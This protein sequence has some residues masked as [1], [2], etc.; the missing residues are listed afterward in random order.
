MSLIT[1]VC[2][3]CLIYGLALTF[4]ALPAVW[5]AEQPQASRATALLDAVTKAQW[6]ELQ[7]WT[8]EFIL[9]EAKTIL[10][11]IRKQPG[12]LGSWEPWVMTVPVDSKVQAELQEL[13]TQAGA[14]LNEMQH[15]DWE[16]LRWYL[17]EYILWQSR[18]YEGDTGSYIDDSYYDFWLRRCKSQSADIKMRVYRAKLQNSIQAHGAAVAFAATLT[19]EDLATLRIWAIGQGQEVASA[20]EKC[21]QKPELTEHWEPWLLTVPGNPEVRARLQEFGELKKS[22]LKEAADDSYYQDGASSTFKWYL[23]EYLRWQFGLAGDLEALQ[24]LGRGPENAWLEILKLKILNSD[25]TA[26]QKASAYGRQENQLPSA[27]LVIQGNSHS[28]EARH[29][30]L[31]QASYDPLYL[32]P[33]RGIII[34]SRP[35]GLVAYEMSTGKELWRNRV[36]QTDTI[37]EYFVFN[38]YIFVYQC[39]GYMSGQIVI[40]DT[41]NGRTIWEKDVIGEGYEG[42]IDLEEHFM[43]LIT[44]SLAIVPLN[45]DLSEEGAIKEYDRNERAAADKILSELEIKNKVSIYLFTSCPLISNRV[46]NYSLLLDDMKDICED[47]EDEADRNMVWLDHRTK[48][49]QALQFNNGSSLRPGLILKVPIKS[50]MMGDEGVGLGV[51]ISQNGT[52]GLNDLTGAKHFFQKGKH[53]ASLASDLLIQSQGGRTKKHLKD[54][55]LKRIIDDTDPMRPV[56]TLAPLD[57]P[58]QGLAVRFDLAKEMAEELP[59]PTVESTLN[60]VAVAISAQQEAAIGL[61]DGSLWRLSLRSGQLSR[62]TSP[63]SQ[64]WSAF[65][66]SPDSRWLA[67]ADHSGQVYRLDFTLE[68][69]QFEPLFKT[70]SPVK[71]IRM[72][73]DGEKIWTINYEATTP[74]EEYEPPSRLGFWSKA[75]GQAVFERTRKYIRFLAYNPSLDEAS[76]FDISDPHENDEGTVDS[77][78]VRP[79]VAK[80]D[81]VNAKLITFHSTF[82]MCMDTSEIIDADNYGQS[83]LAACFGSSDLVG[84]EPYIIDSNNGKALPLNFANTI[85]SQGPLEGFCSWPNSALVAVMN[86]NTFHI[87]NAATGTPL[88]QRKNNG[89]S[90]FS[91]VHCLA[92]QPRLLTQGDNGF[93]QLW[94]LRKPE[95]A[96]LLSWVFFKNGNYAVID[97]DFRFDTSNIDLLEEGI[98]WVVSRLPD[99]TMTM[100]V[101]WRDYYQPRLAEYVL[102]GKK[103]PEL[104]SIDQLNLTQ[105][106]V[107]LVKVEPESE[108]PD[109]VAVTVEVYVRADDPHHPAQELKLFRDGRLVGKFTGENNGLFDLP[110][111]KRQVTF[112]NIALPRNK[113]Q[114]MFK[115]WAFNSDG[116]RSK[117]FDRPYKYEP[118]AQ[119]A[120][121]LHLVSIGVNDFDN[122]AWNLKYA[123]NDA[124]GFAR[125]LP[126]SLP[127]VGGDIRIL[128]SDTGNKPTKALIKAALLQ[129]ADGGSSPDDVIALTISS[130]GLTDDQDNRFY[131]IP[132]DIPGQDK[133]VT[134]ELLAHSISADELSDWLTGVDATEIVMILDT[135]QSGAALGGES[136]KPGPM[137]DKGLGQMAYDKAMRILSATNENNA[138]MELGDLGHGLLSYALLVDGL[139]N[140]LA[141]S[142]DGFTFKQWLAYGRERTAELYAKIAKGQSIG[143]TR[144]KVKVQK[145]ADNANPPLGQEP[146]LFDFGGADKEVIRFQPK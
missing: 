49:K 30:A 134:P 72:G 59:G 125:I 109:K 54:Y 80:L 106:G 139:E 77:T 104:P 111:G 70:P 117:Y 86:Y 103:L 34:S 105:H 38:D 31:S 74:E 16:L 124:Q 7:L 89:E 101:L 17:F 27:K 32:S 131:I 87:I 133:K 112:H 94:D 57:Q 85:I 141:G 118:E 63:T 92:G 10:E 96:N 12:L 107:R 121:K 47:R 51:T 116:V 128:A 2:R 138:A 144:G 35:T 100:P 82:K 23:E 127:G 24:S 115:S 83:V 98:H 88:I 11:K 1:R 102:A 61:D 4:T 145:T 52:M 5:A 6:N 36:G 56:C 126:A 146:Y 71:F 58:E 14:L 13:N 142:K 55:Y 33:E 81:K 37:V 97:S 73:R 3:Q 99:Q 93:L 21:L 40:I 90:N 66:F 78:R 120:P 45:S 137:G 130:H 140:G 44:D 15:S 8:Q 42:G 108:A 114:V 28:T 143:D 95:P 22:A 67:V 123:V 91:S 46:S 129:L 75:K 48:V 25:I 26:A 122:P 41:T 19:R 29:R 64:A 119:V 65:D 132:A 53:A 79:E 62:L 43:A 135:C 110:E 18:Q 68:P 76:L 60:V 113:N 39:I 9:P 84:V 50:P 20:L 69:P 136:F